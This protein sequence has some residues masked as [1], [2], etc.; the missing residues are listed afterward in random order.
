MCE[1][2]CSHKDCTSCSYPIAGKIPTSKWVNNLSI[3]CNTTQQIKR[4]E[5]RIC[6]TTWMTIERNYPERI[7]A[8]KK[9]ARPN[10]SLITVW[11]HLHR[12]L[13]NA[14]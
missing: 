10:E 8:K 4:K 5:P 1:S 7:Q 14:N 13:E 11:I 12:I 9:E 2:I 6:A 3:R